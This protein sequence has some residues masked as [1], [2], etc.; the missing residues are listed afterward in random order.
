MKMATKAVLRFD[1][2]RAD[3]SFRA[4]ERL[5]KEEVRAVELARSIYRLRRRREAI[6]GNAL[7]AEPGWD[8]LLDLYL[9]AKEKRRVSVSCACI[10]SVV[11]ATTALR[12]IQQLEKESVIV[13]EIDRNDARRF[14]LRLTPEGLGKMEAL[15]GEALALFSTR[16]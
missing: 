12:W 7:F 8:I 5:T 4:E 16:T 9:A 6:F 2:D 14:H 3:S 11:P 10:A 15:L 1:P 13:R